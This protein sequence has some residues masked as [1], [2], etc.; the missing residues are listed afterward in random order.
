MTI[1]A[2]ALLALST[3]GITAAIKSHSR[4]PIAFCPAAA[5]V[6]QTLFL[7]VFGIFGILRAGAVTLFALGL[8]AL[9]YHLVSKREVFK[10]L[11]SPAI[12]FFVLTTAAL[13]IYSL[14]TTPYS[15][16]NF[17]H[18]CVITK[19]LYN[20]N[21][22]PVEG[23]M[24]TFTNYPPATALYE[25]FVLQ[26]T[27]FG[28]SFM[29]AAINTLYVS[30]LTCM[31][32]NTSFK[33]PL[34]VLARI[35]MSVPLLFVVTNSCRSLLV[36]AILGFTLLA[37]GIC[38]LWDSSF[39]RSA[40][41]FYGILSAFLVLTKMSGAL[42]VAVHVALIIMLSVIRLKRG[43][44]L[45]RSW[46]HLAVSAA[47]PIIAS[48]SFS[49]YTK[50]VF[51]TAQKNE[52]VLSISNFIAK[53]T[54]KSEKFWDTF[55]TKFVSKIFDFSVDS[56]VFFMICTI[57]LVVLTVA[58]VLTKAV[59]RE[60]LSVV[61]FAFC[62]LVFY[63][64]FLAFMYIFLMKEHDSIQV[65]S[66]AR[67][68]GSG[69]IYQLGL[70]YFALSFFSAE[71]KKALSSSLSIIGVSLAVF[72]LSSC[73]ALAPME[74]SKQRSIDRQIEF[75]KDMFALS[76]EVGHIFADNEIHVYVA[77]NYNKVSAGNAYY[78]LRYAFMR[79]RVW[80]L[81]SAMWLDELFDEGGEC[82]ILWVDDYKWA[83]DRLKKCGFSI[84]EPGLYFKNADNELSLVCEIDY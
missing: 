70:S 12:L 84:T 64:L 54:G 67:Y 11:L 31:F 45:R 51:E 20:T 61:I 15:Y 36:D 65:A 66:F 71:E 19:E 57:G 52:F 35:A 13:V 14:N 29:L 47:A 21:A 17:T 49:I 38:A 34:V 7:Y 42:F 8:L 46:I 80:T 63:T 73:L 56:S 32:V 60:A 82:Y 16:D 43:E 50:V 1:L 23:T 27:G 24:V 3:L 79:T 22:L 75:E 2:L 5:L 6:S 48:L 59:K 58:L 4:L 83:K 68:F 25:Y 76:E 9:G 55:P 74:A 26:F 33:K 39:S 18:W 28:E 81:S 69:V 30:L 72:T 78:I 10:E 37:L 62:A 40:V 53:A 77:A 41:F 44:R